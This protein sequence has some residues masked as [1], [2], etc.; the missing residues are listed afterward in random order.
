M[1]SNAETIFQQANNLQ[2]NVQRYLGNTPNWHSDLFMQPRLYAADRLDIAS[3]YYPVPREVPAR[4]EGFSGYEAAHEKIST[5]SNDPIKEEEVSEGMINNFLVGCDPEFV[6]LKA[7]GGVMDVKKV[8]L[9]DNPT[10]QQQDAFYDAEVGYDHGGRVAELRP[11]PC[12]GTY[13]LIKKLQKL[14]QSPRVEELLKAGASKLRAGAR[15]GTE[16]LGGHVHFGFTRREVSYRHDAF[17]VPTLGADGKYEVIDPEAD[18]IKSLDLLVKLLEHLDILPR[19]E[20]IRRRQGHYGKFSDVRDSNGHMEYRTMASWLFDP[21]VAFTCLTA[22]KIA[23]ADPEGTLES[24]KGVTSFQGLVNWVEK[25]KT[26]DMN[27]RRLKE[28][29]L[30]LGHPKVRID[31]DVNLVERWEEI[32]F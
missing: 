17:G 9:G 1:P 15:G 19:D 4:R 27:A 20:S 12:K 29:V 6:G 5:S 10:S 8:W 22:A 21:K 14:I 30:D 24:L 16:S 2:Q 7:D 31:P 23:A 26:K 28:K 32:G 25:Y 3:Y 11:G 18:K 13:A